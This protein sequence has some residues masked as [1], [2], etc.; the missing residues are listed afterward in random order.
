MTCTYPP[1]YNWRECNSWV[2]SCG[3]IHAW[4]LR[5]SYSTGLRSV[6]F[7]TTQQAVIRSRN[8]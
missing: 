5:T 4:S 8:L 3:G 6:P 7:R 1:V 2:S